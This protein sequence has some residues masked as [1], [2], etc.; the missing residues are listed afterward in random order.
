M[1]AKLRVVLV[2]PSKYTPEGDVERFQTGFMPNATLYH[3]ASLTPR[4]INGVAVEVETVDEYVRCD[5]D[6]LRLLEAKPGLTTL[7]AMVGVQSH[8]FHRAL[9][10]AAY[11]RAHG[12]EH[13]IIG[14]P[15]PMT[16]DTSMLQGKGVSFAL[17]EAELSWEQ[18]LSDALEGSLQECYGSE[19]RWAQTLDGPVIN[20]PPA[21]ELNRYWART[22]GIYPVRGCPY[23]C[24]YCSVIKISGR[25]VRSQSID[26][27]I[28][29]LKKA[30]AAGVERIFFVSDNFN[31]FPEVYDLL[32]AMIEEKLDLTFFCQCDT[33]VAKQ[34]ELVELLGKAGCFEIF[35]GVESLN[36]ETLKAVHKHHN[37]PDSYGSIIELCEEAGIRS[38]FSSIVG[39]PNQTGQDIRD[40]VASLK[41][42]GPRVASFYVLTPIPGTEQ[43]DEYRQSG[44]LVENNLDRYDTTC[45]T[46][47]HPNMSKT[48]VEDWLFWSYK[49][50]Y[51]SLLR[52]G[53]LWNE[54]R[55]LAFFNYL[56]AK[57]R[58]HPNAG[59]L[60]RTTVDKL[61]QYIEYRKRQ[62]GYELAP[63]PDSL[64]LSSADEATNRKAKLKAKLAV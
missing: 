23:R 34:P 22:L 40:H 27:T 24:N 61:D 14:G 5:V 32:R 2:K 57:Q 30:Q 59:G 4:S 53:E 8:Q 51:G 28:K 42:L 35:L 9:D 60:R 15:H 56:T 55:N 19:R 18:I 44:L 31:K 58:M 36:R 46:W 41:K 45:L 10:L 21:D 20:P 3:I 43:Y 47:Q 49:S 64:A 37:H 12:V 29:S 50:F 48:E 26:T 25:Q 13:C 7:L 17:A 1:T 16:C 6:Y 54:Q 33:Q 62:Y 52:R 11:A 39:F 38:H 63:L